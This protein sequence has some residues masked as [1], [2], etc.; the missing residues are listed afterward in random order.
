MPNQ[1]D[2]NSGKKGPSPALQ[3]AMG[4]AG[5]KTQAIKSFQEFLDLRAKLGFHVLNV[6][7]VILKIRESIGHIHFMTLDEFIMVFVDLFRGKFSNYYE[8]IDSLVQ[9]FH[10]IDL[11]GKK[12]FHFNY[13]KFL[14]NG[15]LEL[16]ETLQ[17]FVH[18][19]GGSEEDKI[20][21]CNIL[22]PD[23]L[24][25]LIYLAFLL[26]DLDNSGFLDSREV[27]ELVFNTIKITQSK[28]DGN[29][30]LLKN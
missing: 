29:I 10:F 1:G 14:G 2:Q 30:Y 19:F 24:Y 27:F 13:N 22:N 28:G 17:A 5:R 3:T 6:K 23:G 20:R 26:F 11:N 8:F 4:L 9:I 18:L 25:I 16:G 12:H 21:A 15:A 7:E